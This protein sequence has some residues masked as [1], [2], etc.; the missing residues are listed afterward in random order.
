[1]WTNI[2]ATNHCSPFYLFYFLNFTG[3]RNVWFIICTRFNIW[4]SSVLMQFCLNVGDN[5]VTILSTRHFTAVTDWWFSSYS[6]MLDIL[7]TGIEWRLNTLQL[8]SLLR[9]TICANIC[10][11]PHTRPC[12]CYE[13]ILPQFFVIFIKNYWNCFQIFFYFFNIQEH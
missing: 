13:C 12:V 9:L 10:T 5:I 7:S 6:T 4:N 3:Y 2:R 8:C 1:M 11:Q